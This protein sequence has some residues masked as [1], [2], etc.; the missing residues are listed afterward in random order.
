MTLPRSPHAPEGAALKQNRVFGQP[1]KA[2]RNKPRFRSHHLLIATTLFAI[3]N[4]SIASPKVSELLAQL[5]QIAEAVPLTDPSTVY[6]SLGLVTRFRVRLLPD[7]VQSIIQPEM[8]KGTPYQ[9]V[10]L[11]PYRFT[12]RPPS[13][14]PSIYPVF[15]DSSSLSVGLNTREICITEVD[16]RSAF[17]DPY[18]TEQMIVTDGGGGEHL[19]FQVR[20]PQEILGTATFS[21]EKS[22]HCASSF[23]VHA[24]F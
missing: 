23:G 15:P 1:S 7:H 17:G 18:K 11:V 9:S 14:D 4:S 3:C 19:K 20:R 5:K 13:R 22:N 21:F 24:P 8:L 10:W 16:V 2:T 12:L 6:S